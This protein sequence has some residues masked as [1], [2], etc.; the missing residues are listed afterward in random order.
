M[1]EGKS[2]LAA[3]SRSRWVERNLPSLLIKGRFLIFEGTGSAKVERMNPQMNPRRESPTIF[4]E[5]NARDRN[6]LIFQQISSNFPSTSE[7]LVVP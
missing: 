5:Y 3:L 1:N 6:P 4:T 2:E 7:K